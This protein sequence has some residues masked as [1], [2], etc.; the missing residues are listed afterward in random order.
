MDEREL[1]QEKEVVQREEK[2][3]LS[4][5]P[6]PTTLE[7]DPSTLPSMPEDDP[8]GNVNTESNMAAPRWGPQHAGAKA[9]AGMYSQG[10]PLG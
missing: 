3:F 8:N 5:D 2:R 9:L 7:C 1:E 10:E 6:A 4:P